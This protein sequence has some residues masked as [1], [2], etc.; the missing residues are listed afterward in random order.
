MIGD[1]S[2]GSVDGVVTITHFDDSYAPCQWPVADS[3]F[4]AI[5][6]LNT[7][8]NCVRLSFTS[9]KLSN[10]TSNN[11]HASNFVVHY[12]PQ[13][14]NPPLNLVI[15]LG[16]DS[17]GTYDAPPAR[18]EREGND[19]STA[20]KKYRMA[21]YLWQAYTHEQMERSKLGR[22]TFR[23][24]EEWTTGTISARD[25]ATDAMR[26]EA[27]VHVVRSQKTVAEIRDADVAQQNPT[28]KR[29]GDL[30]S[31]A[32]DD[33]KQHFGARG[34]QKQYCAVLILD[35]HWDKQKNMILGH[36]ALGGG[37]A[38][39]GLAVF[40]SHALHSYP[41]C[42]EEVVPAFTDCTRTDTNFVAND[43]GE[44]GSNWEAANI[45]IGAHMHEVG[46]LFGCPHQESGIMLR[47]YVTLNRSFVA[48]EAY[49]T[50]TGSKGMLC[51]KE[52]E[53]NWHKLDLLRMRIHPCF[54]A[55]GDGNLHKDSSVEIW[56]VETGIFLVAPSGIAYME[57]FVEG[58]DMI[59]GWME[60]G[61]GVSRG[62]IQRQ[63]FVTEAD[64]RARLPESLRKRNVRVQAKSFGN[65]SAESS[66]ICADK[67]RIV[68]LP[69]QGITLASSKRLAFLGH[70]HGLSQT[71]GS[72]KQQ[73]IFESVL[74]QKSVM[75]AVI[76]YWGFALNG[77]EF[78]YEDSST[79]VFGVKSGNSAR[80]N[81][82]LRR[83]EIISGF[84]IRAGF[85]VDGIQ[86]LTS[87]GRASEMF[88]AANLGSGYVLSM[89]FMDLCC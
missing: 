71:E 65:G 87:T 23:F 44:S 67:S 14:Q 37:D 10:I 3:T 55:P 33:V 53:C 38:N 5:I 32:M 84:N 47:D 69:N 8:K 83:G 9:P 35:A 42:V 11:I 70:K 68:K 50:R 78:C 51:K 2:D 59:R 73:I 76:A 64:V 40:G 31:W 60:F 24:D 15:L 58:D 22:R 66:V 41:S 19:L 63:Y 62:Q 74:A 89:K 26:S 88:G 39:M 54:R 77:L 28:A 85:W 81:L 1:G 30:F 16:K 57:I 12:V 72:E 46:H 25:H 48:K 34:G 61:D 86:I 13:T 6:P 43:C 4:K 79:Q 17:P 21:A 75:T 18:A 7:G 27:R 52:N 29:A 36:A 80:F 20:I 45:G 82:D 49:S 56:P